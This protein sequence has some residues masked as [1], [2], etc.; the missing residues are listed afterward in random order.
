MEADLSHLCG[1]KLIGQAVD[2][3]GIQGINGSGHNVGIAYRGYIEAQSAFALV[4]GEAV[5]QRAV[6][7]PI[8]GVVVVGIVAVCHLLVMCAGIG[9]IREVEDHGGA[10][11]HIRYDEG[12]VGDG[13]GIVG[14]VAN[15]MIGK[16]SIS[17][18][19]DMVDLQQ[20]I[21]T[22]GGAGTAVHGAGVQQETTEFLS[23]VV[24]V[25][26]TGTNDCV[27]IG[28]AQGIDLVG[29]LFCLCHTLGGLVSTGSPVG[30]DEGEL[31]AGG[32]DGEHC[33][34]DALAVTAGVVGF[35]AVGVEGQKILAVEYAVESLAL[36]GDIIIIGVA[37]NIGFFQPAPL[38]AVQLGEGGI[39]GGAHFLCANYHGVVFVE[40]FFQLQHTGGGGFGSHT[41]ALPACEFRKD[42][43]THE[44]D[45]R[46]GILCGGYGLGLRHGKQKG[47]DQ[48][49]KQEYDDLFLHF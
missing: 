18:S 23:L 49:H 42:I 9:I 3:L 32:V 27:C 46:R 22:D 5:D 20:I 37:R 43:G 14:F 26:V 35:Y 33:P 31:L 25:K 44:T 17:R 36:V 7:S 34:D 19:G 38:T 10:E 21:S 8:S 29:K 48:S 40:H 13:I 11:L 12:V 16:G 6:V 47:Q 41:V 1:S 15:G 2:F 30:A 4:D 39:P 28:T 24:A 45:I